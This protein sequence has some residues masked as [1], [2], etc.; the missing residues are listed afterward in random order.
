[1]ARIGIDID[2]TITDTSSSIKY[3]VEKYAKDYKDGHILIEREANIIRGFFDHEVIVQFFL[4]HGKDIAGKAKLRKYAKEVIEQLRKE[5]HEIIFI[6]ARSNQYYT[7][8]KKFC[9]DYL[10]ENNVQYDKVLTG[11]TFKVKACQNEGIDIMID[12]GVDTC[13]DLNKA[14]I[15]AFLYS[16][17]INKRK[18]VVS[19]RVN[20]WKETYEKIHEYLEEN[21]I[22]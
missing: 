19:P 8:A 6:T 20:S 5:G 3:Y 21:N 15:K 2:D 12:D 1:M 18:N 16:T 11:Q 7:D 17:P 22:K 9:E 14:G 10:N 4:D 13:C